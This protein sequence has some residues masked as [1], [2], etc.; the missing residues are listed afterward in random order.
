MTLTKRALV[1]RIN[2]ETGLLQAEVMAVV[3]KTLDAIAETL[4]QGNKV[5][6]RNFGVFAVVIRKA[7]IGRNPK[8]P[9][10]EVPIPARAMVKFKV[11]KDMKH[12]VLKLTTKPRPQKSPRAK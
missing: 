4:A 1:M 3:Q 12:E 2:A 11:G 9:E 10:K 7:R 5:E 6:L 8:A